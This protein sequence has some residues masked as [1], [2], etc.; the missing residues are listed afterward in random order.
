MSVLET[1][2]RA[3]A[4]GVVVRLDDGEIVAE[5]DTLPSAIIDELKAIRPGLMRLLKARQASERAMRAERPDD[6]WMHRWSEAQRGLV[7]FIH[8]GWGDR[9]ALL[10]WTI[11]EL[12]RLP[13][14]WSQIHLTGCAWLVGDKRV[15]AATEASIVIE[16]SQGSRLRFRRI[17]R[18][19]IA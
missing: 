16:A 2:E 11:E 3:E 1:I 10:G 4:A 17:G 7:G 19:H 14:L 8:D 6:C 13:P 12:Y 5:A 18:E 9:A 15:V